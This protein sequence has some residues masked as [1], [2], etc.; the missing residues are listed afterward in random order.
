MKTRAAKYA[1]KLAQTKDEDKRC[2]SPHV[3]TRVYRP[4]EILVLHADYDQ[5]VDIWS[6]GCILGEL[7]HH[8]QL[9]RAK[10]DKELRSRIDVNRE[11]YLFS[12][13]SSYPLSPCISKEND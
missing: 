9:E 1:M 3:V 12:G 8:E 4:P 6:L 13:D 11:R 5:T 2:L 10:H 7:M